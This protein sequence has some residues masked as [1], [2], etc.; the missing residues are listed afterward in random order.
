VADND[1]HCAG[2]DGH[3]TDESPLQHRYQRNLARATNQPPVE[4]EGEPGKAI[5][6]SIRADEAEKWR[7]ALLKEWVSNHHDNCGRIQREHDDYG[8]SYPL[9]DL[10][11][12]TY[13]DELT[14]I[15]DYEARLLSRPETSDD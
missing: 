9:A 15:T 10:L 7:E 8:C 14:A 2:C 12:E 6:D 4:H 11:R 3:D 13:P 1:V 5:E